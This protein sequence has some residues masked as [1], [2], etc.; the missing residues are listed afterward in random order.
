MTEFLSRYYTKEE[1]FLREFGSLAE[2]AANHLNDAWRPNY[3]CDDAARRNRD[4][5]LSSGELSWLVFDGAAVYHDVNGFSSAQI[6]IRTVARIVTIRV[7]RGHHGLVAETI[8]DR[9]ASQ[10]V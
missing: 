7:K 9:D 6:I 3:S 2:V 1:E 10:H 5:F 8:V 4:Y